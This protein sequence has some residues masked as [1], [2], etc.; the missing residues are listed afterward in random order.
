[1]NVPSLGQ[2]ILEAIPFIENAIRRRGRRAEY[3][4]LLGDARRDAGDLEG[5]RA[6]WRQAL[7]IDPDDRTAHERLGE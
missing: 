6:A 7:E 3:R 1:M 4:V 2:W 5:A